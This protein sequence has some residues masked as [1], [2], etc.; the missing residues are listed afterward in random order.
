MG[1]MQEQWNEFVTNLI[2][3]KRIPKAQYQ[4]IRR[5]F[6]AGFVSTMKVFLYEITNLSDDEFDTALESL[7]KEADEFLREI[8]LVVE[9]EWKNSENV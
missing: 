6:F 8:R 7:Q 5:C 4:I 9:A 2:R 1:R 3:H